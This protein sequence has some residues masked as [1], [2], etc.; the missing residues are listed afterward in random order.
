MFQQGTNQSIFMFALESHDIV[1][2]VFPNTI[3]VGKIKYRV[4]QILGMLNSQ[5]QALYNS[6]PSSPLRAGQAPAP[7]INDL[8]YG[9]ENHGSIN[10]ASREINCKIVY[11]GPGLAARRPTCSTSST[12]SPPAREQDDLACDRN[13][14]HAV[15][16]LPA[17]RPR[18][19][20]GLQDPF[21]LYTVPGQVYYNASRKLILKGVDGVV[22]VAD[23]QKEWEANIESL[24]NMEENLA[25]Y[26][27]T[28]DASPTFSSTTSATFPTST[29]T[30]SSKASSIP[31][32]SPPSRPW[33]SRVPESS[34]PSRPSP[35][36]S[37]TAS[38]R[39]ARPALPSASPDMT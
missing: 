19:R 3:T 24:R 25:E 23:S 21:Q 33:P 34:R 31:V 14:A 32:T 13:R 4:E 16:R 11:Y 38:A 22:F 39:R 37:S 5:I 7:K 15:L 12:S 28:L 6:A 17:P 18:L 26:G 10:Y 30:R 1:A 27:L 35:R 2:V 29:P 36:P 20:A 9:V 8:F